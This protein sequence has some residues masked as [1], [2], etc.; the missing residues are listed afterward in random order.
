ML[1]WQMLL[2]MLWVKK[3]SKPNAVLVDRAVNAT[4]TEQVL[5]LTCQYFIHRASWMG[6]FC[7]FGCCEN[8]MEQGVRR[9][10]SLKW[11]MSLVTQAP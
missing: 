1:W 8:K 6:V 10:L 4:R 7:V 5:Y 2:L 9:T 11:R 3:D